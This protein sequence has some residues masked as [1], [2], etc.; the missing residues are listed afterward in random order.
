MFTAIA[1]SDPI[2]NVM[3]ENTPK[4]IKNGALSMY[5]YVTISLS[6]ILIYNKQP[7]DCNNV[8]IYVNA[9]NQKTISL[10]DGYAMLKID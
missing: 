2:A 6:H 8:Q 4:L 1:F 9:F 3:H 7:V 5:I 10:S